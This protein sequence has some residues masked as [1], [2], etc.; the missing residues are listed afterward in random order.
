MGHLNNESGE[1]FI[2]GDRVTITG[3]TLDGGTFNVTNLAIASLPNT[4]DFTFSQSG[5]TVALTANTGNTR[6]LAL[7]YTQAFTWYDELIVSRNRIA[8]PGAQTVNVSLSPGT[9]AFGNSAIGLASP[10]QTATLTNTGTSLLTI[11]G[12]SIVGTADFSQTNNCPASLAAGLNCAITMTFTPHTLLPVLATL[13]VS[14]NAANNPQTVALSGTG[15]GNV[16][17]V[18]SISGRGVIKAGP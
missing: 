4:T 9:I 15:I 2:V 6:N 8:D 14:D 10:S 1:C 13:T 16:I 5:N 18:G 11:T 17:G 7:V 3:T 12:I